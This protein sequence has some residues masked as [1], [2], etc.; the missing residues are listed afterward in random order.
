MGSAQRDPY[1]SP[2]LV[3]G[4]CFVV[5]FVGGCPGVD[6]RA[7]R[8]SD[9][10]VLY[11]PIVSGRLLFV[12][13]SDNVVGGA[14][15]AKAAVEEKCCSADLS[16]SK[17]LDLTGPRRSRV[18]V[19]SVLGTDGHEFPV[20]RGDPGTLWSGKRGMPCVSGGFDDTIAIV[21]GFL[22][23]LRLLR[24]VIFLFEE[25]LLLGGIN[26]IFTTA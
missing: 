15:S 8:V 13:T 6:L 19:S 25:M 4:V 12:T 16:V 26:F 2:L 9:R 23:F 11:C 7:M 10:R 3:V 24:M 14:R 5:L 21:T 17:F 22:G 18:V 20:H 1:W